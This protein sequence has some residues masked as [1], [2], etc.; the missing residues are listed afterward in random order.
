MGA[1]VIRIVAATTV[2]MVVIATA[3]CSGDD[4]GVSDATEPADQ[5][6]IDECDWPMWGQRID[7]TFSYPCDTEISPTTAPDLR[8]LWFFNADDTVTATPA[9]V[10]D[11]V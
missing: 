1:G 4:G 9:V 6:P 3:A 5:G 2:T 8:Q 11:T 10:D 7:H